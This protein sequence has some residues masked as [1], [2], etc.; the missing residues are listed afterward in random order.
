[1]AAKTIVRV[2]NPLRD[3]AIAHAEV[4]PGYLIEL[5]STGK[6]QAQSTAGSGTCE[7]AFAIEDDL[8]G[9]DIAT[10]YAANKLVQYAIFKS[11][12]VV[13]AVLAD[14]DA[15][16]IG[17]KLAANG[18]GALHVAGTGDTAIAIALEAVD[19]SDTATTPLASRRV[20]ARLL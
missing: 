19:A 7:K 9:N 8:Q 17:S 6:V 13:R 5:L 1:M 11:G 14:G 16:V 4:Y 3:E 20:D 18:A 15:C 10:A 12:E 2:G